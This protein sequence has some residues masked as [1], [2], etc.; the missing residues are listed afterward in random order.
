MRDIVSRH[1][2]IHD[3]RERRSGDHRFVLRGI[4]INVA[5]T[6]C[7][8]DRELLAECLEVFDE[9]CRP[10]AIVHACAQKFLSEAVALK[11]NF[12]RGSRQVKS[13]LEIGHVLEISIRPL[14]V[15]LHRPYA[16]R[17]CFILGEHYAAV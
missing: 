2:Q 10:F 1:N 5:P 15:G 16:K 11:M 6:C 9:L 3:F 8:N 14:A 7:G 13:S 12:F 17:S 4:N